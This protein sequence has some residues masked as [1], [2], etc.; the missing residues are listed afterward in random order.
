[1]YE[2]EFEEESFAL[3]AR[4]LGWEEAAYLEAVREVPRVS[5]A[6][7]ASYLAFFESLARVVSAA[8]GAA[9]RPRI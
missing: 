6:K 5:R 9:R 8:A 2:D 4:E 7:M 1:V 3:R